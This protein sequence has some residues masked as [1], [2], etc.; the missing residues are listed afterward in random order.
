MKRF[1]ARL[2]F[3]VIALAAAAG[4]HQQGAGTCGAQGMLYDYTAVNGTGCSVEES[5]EHAV[6]YAENGTFTQSVTGMNHSPRSSFPTVSIG[7]NIP[8]PS[9]GGR[10]IDLR[11]VITIGRP[12]QVH[13]K[14]Y[15]LR[16]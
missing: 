2:A 12:Y 13:A 14:L 1:F 11:D 10:S 3:M 8:S 5:M 4:M 15:V 9:F 16:V 7:N 6:A